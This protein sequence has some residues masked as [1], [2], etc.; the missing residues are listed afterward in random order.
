MSEENKALLIEVNKR[1]ETMLRELPQTPENF[2]LIHGDMHVGNVL[3]EDDH[4]NVIDFDDTSFAFY[5]YDFSAILAYEAPKPNYLEVRDGLFRGYESVRPLPPRTDELLPLF[6]QSRLAG[7]SDWVLA[8]M[9][10]PR[11]REKGPDFI[12]YLCDSIRAVQRS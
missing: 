4:L 1:A 6:I 11:M 3:F 7:V 10:N 8:R 2:G 9:D 12:A 5:L